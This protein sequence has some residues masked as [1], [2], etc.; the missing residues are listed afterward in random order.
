MKDLHSANYKT[1]MKEIEDN[2]KKCKDII[3]CSRIGRTNMVKVSPK[4]I[5]TFNVSKYHQ[6]FSQRLEETILKWVWN[7][8]RPRIAKATLKKQSQAGGVTIPDVKLYYEGV[9]IETVWH[10]HKNRHIDQWNSIE[11]PEMAPQLQGQLIFDK[12]GKNRPWEKD[13]LFN[14]WCWENWTATCKRLKLDHSLTPY[15]KMNSKWMKDLNVRPG[16]IKIL[17]E[18][19]GSR[20]SDLGPSNIFLDLS[21]EAREVKAKI[22]YWDCSLVQC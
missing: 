4:A 14:N 22:N 9:A 8:K 11:N 16:T 21:P 5:C 10:W 6:H 1:L 15:T 12:A 20:V 17:E 13:S 18:S 3:P 19:T 7:H 2:G